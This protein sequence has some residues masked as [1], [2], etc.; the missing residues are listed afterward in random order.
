MRRAECKLAMIRC[1]AECSHREF[2]RDQNSSFKN[3]STEHC[4][5]RTHC[6]MFFVVLLAH[7][8][9]CTNIMDPIPAKAD[10]GYAQAAVFVGQSMPACRSEGIQV[11]CRRFLRSAIRLAA[12][13]AKQ[14]RRS[15][16]C[17][18]LRANQPFRSRAPTVKRIAGGSLWSTICIQTAR[19][20][21]GI[22]EVANP[23]ISKSEVRLNPTEKLS[24]I[25]D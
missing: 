1:Y 10:E 4:Q 18:R 6:R 2:L 21:Q 15:G 14:L 7:L 22:R 25:E 9:A 16:R 23:S 17:L 20:L 8:H 3:S 19:W 12:G 11:L 5:H 24:K 13:I